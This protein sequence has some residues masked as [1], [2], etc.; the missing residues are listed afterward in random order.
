MQETVE[1]I[2]EKVTEMAALMESLQMSISVLQKSN[3]HLH[4][5]VKEVYTVVSSPVISV[6]CCQPGS[7]EPN[8]RSNL[9]VDSYLGRHELCLVFLTGERDWHSELTRAD[10]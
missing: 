1:E 3:R 7:S 4:E 2:K 9:L 5:T 8:I 10:E 6:V